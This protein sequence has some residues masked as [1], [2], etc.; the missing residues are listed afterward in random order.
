MKIARRLPTS[1][2][3][4]TMFFVL[5]VIAATIVGL[6]Q[7]ASIWL[8]SVGYGGV[9]ALYLAHDAFEHR[10]RMSWFFALMGSLHFVLLIA[11]MVGSH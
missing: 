6:A 10:Q 9:G 2:T 11:C 1:F 3:L 7:H 5:V 8:F 4:V